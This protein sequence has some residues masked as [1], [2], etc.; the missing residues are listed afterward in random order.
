MEFPNI[1]FRTIRWI[2]ILGISGLWGSISG[3]I[4]GSG[5]MLILRRS[6]VITMLSSFPPGS[7]TRT[8]SILPVRI[9]PGFFPDWGCLLITQ[10]IPLRIEK[11]DTTR[12]KLFGG[13]AEMVSDGPGRRPKPVLIE[14]S[15]EVIACDT[16]IPAIGQAAEEKIF[17][18][19]DIVNPKRD[20]ISAIANGH[21]A[22]KGIDIYLRLM[23]KARATF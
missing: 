15:E 6:T 5:L 10:A 14:G 16:V 22:A 9:F 19:G 7:L 12:L 20:A 23:Q 3:R 2:R 21:S 1:G 13:R 4:P 11:G 18:G 8:V 17:A